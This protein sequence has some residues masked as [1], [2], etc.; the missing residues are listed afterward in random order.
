MTKITCLAT[1]PPTISAYT[2]SNYSADLYVPIGCK[3]AYESAEYWKKFKNIIEVT[4]DNPITLN[5]NDATVAT[6][7]DNIVVK[8]ARLGGAVNVYDSNGAM[9]KSVTATDGSVV[10]E[11]PI[12]GIYVVAID[13]KSFKVMVK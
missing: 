2:F 6:I 8:N 3:A 9:V 5:D 1:N 13:G 7:G 4:L 11:A 12:K 10:I